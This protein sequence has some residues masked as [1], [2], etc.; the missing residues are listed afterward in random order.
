MKEEIRLKNQLAREKE[1]EDKAKEFAKASPESSEIL[2]N[3]N[4]NKAA[5]VLAHIRQ[6]VFTKED[7]KDLKHFIRYASAEHKKE[8]ANKRPDLAPRLNPEK[9]EKEKNEVIKNTGMPNA[10][11][12]K[13]AENTVIRKKVQGKD[14]KKF[15]EEADV[16]TLGDARV[17]AGLDIKQIREIELKGSDEQRRAIKEVVLKKDKEIIEIAKLLFEEGKKDKRKMAEV[18]R[19]HG[20]LEYIRQSKTFK[21][22]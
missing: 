14:A 15:R 13:A 22:Y 1:I 9:V 20:T 18:A 17:I 2:A 12:Q 5:K 7:E 16:K 11:A 6:G 3:T 4:E 21:S 19:M 10:D 8:V